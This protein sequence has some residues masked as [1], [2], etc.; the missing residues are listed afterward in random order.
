M[1]EDKYRERLTTIKRLQAQ[2][3]QHAHDIFNVHQKSLSYT[4]T[5]VQNM[6]NKTIKKFIV[7]RR[8]DTYKIN[9]C[10]MRCDAYVSEPEWTADSI[11]HHL[12]R[13][14]FDLSKPTKPYHTNP[15]FGSTPSNTEFFIKLQTI[16]MASSE[17]VECLE[18][19]A[20]RP[21]K[22]LAVSQASC[23]SLFHSDNVNDYS[24][25]PYNFAPNKTIRCDG[26][27]NRLVYSP[28]F[29]SHDR[30]GE[31]DQ[32]D[33]GLLLAISQNHHI[34]VIGACPVKECVHTI[35]KAKTTQRAPLTLTPCDQ[36]EVVACDQYEVVATAAAGT[37]GKDVVAADYYRQPL[38]NE[39][40]KTLTAQQKELMMATVFVCATADGHVYFHPGILVSLCLPQKEVL[41]LQARHALNP[42]DPMGLNLS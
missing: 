27:I 34:D 35:L 7:W 2:I 9:T 23:V 41:L 14:T 30:D 39:L 3:Y 18:F 4:V 37:F 26:M 13:S 33:G 15:M 29:M 16:P 20:G 6:Y 17:R 10:G 19:W 22:V 8:T 25:T 36:Y 38:Q 28:S 31:G 21:C 11:R 42:D 32:R 5:S 40:P 1:E 12:L 24:W